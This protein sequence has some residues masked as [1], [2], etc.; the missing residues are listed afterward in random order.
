MTLWPFR[1]LLL[2]GIVLLLIAGGAGLMFLRLNVGRDVVRRAAETRLSAMLR[3]PVSIAG[4]NMSL[5]PVPALVGTGILI[6]PDSKTPDLALERIRIVPR[7]GSLFGGAYVV[8]EITLEGLA[9]RIVREP[10]GYWRFPAVMP[11]PGGEEGSGLVIER[12]RLRGGRVRVWVSSPREGMHETS[13]I[14]DVE[15]E[16]VAEGGALRIS[17]VRGRVGGAAITGDAVVD[18]GTARFDFRMADVKDADLSAV[19]GLAATERPAL[20]RL[21]KPAAAAMSIRIDRQKFRL[22]GTGSLQAPEVA[23]DTLRLQ[24]FAAPIKTDGVRLTLDPTTFSLYGGTHRGA[25]TIDLSSAR[26]RWSLDGNVANLDVG[27]FLAALT[28]RDQP[29]DGTASVA[30]AVRGH[31]GE[32]L[33]RDLEGRVRVNVANGVIRDFPL[34][35]TINRALRLAEGDARDTRF[36]RLSATLMFESRGPISAAGLHGPGYTTTK[37]LVM[38]ARDVRVEAAGRLGFDRSLDLTGQAVLAPE[39]TAAAI[40]SVR[41][42]SGLR[43]DRGELELPLT[44]TGTADRPSIRIDLKAAVGRSIKE[45]LR[46]RLRQFFDR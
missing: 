13:G 19:L 15:G 42:L 37:D 30:V 18:T 17:P 4:V 44:I 5:F 7:L 3:Q 31:V 32:P 25:L 14:D 35:A 21:L 27:K 43:N 40:R 24:D 11:V 41:E 12:V 23:V 16:A 28:A 26:S 29:L 1:R 10:Q 34:L 45:E 39:K 38:Q 36:E 2:V 46:R 9:V 22:S 8:R 33:D 20:L 6:G